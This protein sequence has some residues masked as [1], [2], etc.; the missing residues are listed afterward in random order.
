M[1]RPNREGSQKYGA[2]VER[3]WPRTGYR[4]VLR[5]QFTME[6]NNTDTDRAASDVL[7]ASCHE[8]GD[9]VQKG[10]EIDGSTRRN[11]FAVHDY[12]FVKIRRSGVFEIRPR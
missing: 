7:L 9:G 1:L 6:E 2:I 8:F 12:G 11:E 5:I 3:Q 10:R 4:S